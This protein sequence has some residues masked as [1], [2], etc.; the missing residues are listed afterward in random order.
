M[1]RWDV[2]CASC[3]ACFDA[4]HSNADSSSV[5]RSGSASCEVV[6]FLSAAYLYNLVPELL[7]GDSV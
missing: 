6:G 2:V 1:S 5:P 4:A 7:C 3:V